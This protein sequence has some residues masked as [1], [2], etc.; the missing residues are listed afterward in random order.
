MKAKN[1]IYIICICW[2]TICSYNV[3]AQTPFEGNVDNYVKRIPR[4]LEFMYNSLC[5][6]ASYRD[7]II[8]FAEAFQETYVFGSS[9]V[10]IP[11]FMDYSSKTAQY[12]LDNYLLTFADKYKNY[13]D[14]GTPLEFNISNMQAQEAFWTDDKNGVIVNVIYDNVLMADGKELYNGKSQAVI[15][16]PEQ[17]NPTEFRI[18]QLSAFKVSEVSSSFTINSVSTLA[19]PVFA[20]SVLTSGNSSMPFAQ[21]EKVNKSVLPEQVDLASYLNNNKSEQFIDSV[22]LYKKSSEINQSVQIKLHPVDNGEKAG[23]VDGDG[24]IVVAYQFDFADVF[25]DGLARVCKKD[26]WGFI[27]EQGEI[28]VPLKYDLAYSFHEVGARVKKKRLWGMVDRN[29]KIL[30]PFKYIRI[31]HLSLDYYIALGQNYNWGIFDKAGSTLVECKYTEIG[32]KLQD[33]MIAV[34][35]EGRYGFID[36]HGNVQIPFLKGV[37]LNVNDFWKEGMFPVH[38]GKDPMKNNGFIDKQGQV[39]IPCI[40]EMLHTIGFHF[41]QGLLRLKKDGRWGFVNNKGKVIIDFM[42][43][44]V[45][46]FTDTG[47]SIVRKDG[48]WGAINV[49]G[50]T[51]IPFN[52]QFSKDVENL[53]D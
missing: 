42:Y 35:Y 16:F 22:D 15:V 19:N 44:D 31:E 29:G 23:Y 38:K 49:S 13:I 20:P 47:V 50:Q 43:E 45:Q 6:G 53:L 37:N 52:C 25:Y 11:D 27:N 5:D 33:G 3:S 39:I 30:M 26:K 18:Q 51:V 41:N 48:K 17:S 32:S 8:L 7:E 9:A 40:Y 10:F 24:N 46:D 2:L 28:V 34:L 36:P 14:N 21:T 1:G 4:S 12:S